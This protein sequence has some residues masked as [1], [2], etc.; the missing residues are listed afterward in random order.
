M[1]T[2]THNNDITL[3]N[4]ASVQNMIAVIKKGHATT[5]YFAERE[6][7]LHARRLSIKAKAGEW[8]IKGNPARFYKNTDWAFA[9]K[10]YVEVV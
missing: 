7:I 8:R 10:D 3:F 1:N 6:L 4:V 5:L 9:Q 2:L